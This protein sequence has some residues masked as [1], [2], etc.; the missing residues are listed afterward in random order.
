[1][2]YQKTGIVANG[3]V[4]AVV[5]HNTIVGRGPVGFIAQNGIQLGFGATGEVK[6]NSVA[7][8]WFTL[9]DFVA[10]GILVFEANDV[11]VQGNTMT[12]NQVGTAVEAWCLGAPTADLNRVVANTV[13][14]SQ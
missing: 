13:T 6:W 4:S 7:G 11:T 12:G 14:G 5:T 3:D 8:N 10:A 1:M 9:L 2:E